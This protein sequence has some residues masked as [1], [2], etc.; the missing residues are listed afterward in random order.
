MTEIER[1]KNANWLPSE[2]WR[3]ECQCD[4][5]VTEEKKKVWAICLDL[6]RELHRIC[7]LHNIQCFALAGTVLGAAR[8]KGFIP[9]DDDMD[10]AVPR[11]DYEKLKKLAKEF[12]D[13]YFLQDYT[14][15]T[16]YGFSFMKLRNSNTTALDAFVHMPYNHGIAIDIFPLDFAEPHT[17]E[18]ER[19]EIFN[20]IM[21]NSA[22][23][24]IDKQPQTARDQEV[25]QQY[26]DPSMDLQSVCKEID[27][28]ASSHDN[29]CPYLIQSTCTVYK[30]EKVRW[31]KEIFSS[32][33]ILDFYGIEM[34]VPAGW[35]QM[36]EINYGDWQK[37]PPKEERGIWHNNTLFT[38]IPYKKYYK[39]KLG[40]DLP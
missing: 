13:P 21:K 23:L 33:E 24:R 26:F 37:F 25:I 11:A 30:A 4:Y 35:K 3:E 1:I 36:L 28:I 17:L 34:V 2:F 14:L 9:W 31:P 16:N 10:F 22:R 12:K 5:L 15:E 39:E 18:A 8:H 32:S 20:L 40:I 19:N 6:Y 7:Q 27:R 29:S 38:D